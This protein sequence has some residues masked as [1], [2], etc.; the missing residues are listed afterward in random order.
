MG[1][2]EGRYIGGIYRLSRALSPSPSLALLSACARTGA[3]VRARARARSCV[4]HLDEERLERVVGL[5]DH[6]EYTPVLSEYIY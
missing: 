5:P 6:G 4:A 2:R 1:G 3:V